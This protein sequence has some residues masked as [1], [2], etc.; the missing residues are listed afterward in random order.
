MCHAGS[1]VEESGLS[2]GADLVGRKEAQELEEVGAHGGGAVE[3]QGEELGENDCG[4]LGEGRVDW[5]GEE[6]CGEV[7]EGIAALGVGFGGGGEGEVV[8][9]LGGGGGCGGRERLLVDDDGWVL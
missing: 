9:E 2:A 7:G 4:G 6:L 8:D 1:Y 3:D 5:L